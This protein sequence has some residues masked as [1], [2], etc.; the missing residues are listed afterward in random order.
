MRSM[1][2]DN[3]GVRILYVEDNCQVFSESFL[4]LSTTSGYANFTLT[5]GQ[6]LT[7]ELPVLL[8]EEEMQLLVSHQDDADGTLGDLDALM[9]RRLAARQ[10]EIRLRDLLADIQHYQHEQHHYNWVITI[11]TLAII[12]LMMSHLQMEATTSPRV[13]I[14]LCAATN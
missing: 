6:V 8:T 3:E 5:P 10:Q 7:P 14:T 12:I 11:I 4:L 1:D 9:T 13:R 2:L